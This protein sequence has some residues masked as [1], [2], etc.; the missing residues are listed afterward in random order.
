MYYHLKHNDVISLV[1]MPPR[2]GDEEGMSSTVPQPGFSAAL[3]PEE[4]PGHPIPYTPLLL[5]ASSPQVCSH[6]LPPILD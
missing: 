6:T 3:A 4:A 2:D 5:G 1:P